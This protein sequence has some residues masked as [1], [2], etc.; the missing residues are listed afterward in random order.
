MNLGIKFVKLTNFYGGDAVFIR[1]DKVV[2]LEPVYETY[3]KQLRG[4]YIR[5]ESGIGY[6]VTETIEYVLGLLSADESIILDESIIPDVVDALIE[7][8]NK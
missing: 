4:T 7:L 6:T 8:Q 3:S 1:T 2:V 5:I